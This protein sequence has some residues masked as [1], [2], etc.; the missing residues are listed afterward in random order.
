MQS[1]FLFPDLI[2]YDCQSVRQGLLLYAWY[3]IRGMTCV[4]YIGLAQSHGAATGI[5]IGSTRPD[6]A[7]QRDILLSKVVRKDASTL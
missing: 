5:N 6:E 1:F 7:R 3:C 2:A 4:I